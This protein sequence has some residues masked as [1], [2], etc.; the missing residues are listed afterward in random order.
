MLGG[1]QRPEYGGQVMGRCAAALA[2]CIAWAVSTGGALA[3]TQKTAGPPKRVLLLHS[4]GPNVPPWDAVATRF[5]PELRDQSPY[6]I[7]LYEAALQADRFSP[8]DEQQSFIEYLHALFAARGLD[9]V[10][11]LGAPAARFV[12]QYRPQ[13]FPSTPLLITGADERTFSDAVLSR[14]DTAVAIG[15]D[16]ATQIE[17]ILQV[18]PHTTDIAMLIGDSPLEKFWVDQLQRSYQRF[19]QRVTFRWFNKLS[20]DEMVK[21]ARELPAHSVI[22]SATV[23]VDAQGVPQDGDRIFWRVREVAK[24]PIFSYIDTH[25]GAGIVG[26]PLLS[27]QELAHQAAAVAVRILNGET[28]GDIKTPTLR[29][30][31]PIYDW[32]ELQRWG[33]SE[34]R[35][36]PGSIVEFREPT[37][38]EQYRLQ[39]LAIAAAI[40]LQSLLIVWFAHEHRRR[41]IAEAEA[42][43]RVNELARMNRFATAGQ[44]A[45]SIAHEIRQP[46]SAVVAAATA[47]LNWLKRP[48]PDLAEARFAMEK[49]VEESHHA[50]DVIKGVRAMFRKETQERRQVDLNALIEQILAIAAGPIKSNDILLEA[51]LAKD[52]PPVVTGDPIQLQQVILNLVMNAVEAMRDSADGARTL[53]VETAAT[54][55]GTALIRVNDSGPSVDPKVTDNMFQPFFTTKSGGMGM[56]LS[57]CMS[58]IEAHGG[59]LTATPNNPRGMEFQIVLPCERPKK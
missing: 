23:R 44:L 31:P 5:R 59:M 46:L 41:R 11:A 32:R 16:Q 24:V 7:D 30:G 28:P 58:I 35:L 45:A 14:N 10:V 15:F 53:R 3:Q 2:I 29:P 6:P 20:A 43:Q 17:N 19:T 48:A 55:D 13:I 39:I 56:G 52:A 49:A 57:I 50:D 51:H 36:P 22:Y 27:N 47:G 25:L 40:L 21:S 42:L 18:L 26:G 38:W 34:S 1:I 8:L 54:S 9:L 12:L 33:I 37:A 4:F